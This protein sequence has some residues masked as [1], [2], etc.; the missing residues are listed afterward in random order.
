MGIRAA[1]D[2]W[3]LGDGPGATLRARSVALQALPQSAT[4]D[5]CEMTVVANS[6]G[7]HPACDTLNYPLC[8][9]SELADVFIPVEDGGI[10]T[11]TGVNW[12]RRSD[13]G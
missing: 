13:W 6:T 10:L 4:P 9:I 8:R 11:Q 3:T 2:L 12:G 5:Y 7:L 1:G